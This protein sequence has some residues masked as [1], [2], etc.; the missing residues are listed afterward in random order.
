M[1]APARI[2]FAGTPEFAVPTLDA[3]LKS[4]HDV[5]AVLTQP[6]RPAGRGRKVQFGPVKQAALA[7]GLPVFQPVTLAGVDEQEQ[8]A[9]LS[10]DLMVVVAYGLLLPGTVLQIPRVACV[11]VHASLLPRWRGASPIQAALLAGD[12]ETGVSIMQMDA[13]LDTGPVYCSESLS[14]EPHESAAELHDRL[15]ALGGRLLADVVDTILSGELQATAQ[16]TAG[17]SYAGRIRKADS[18]INWSLPATSI[19]QLIRAYNPWPVAQTS[20]DGKQ[21]RCWAAQVDDRLADTSKQPGTIIGTDE[22]GIQVQTG[23]GV[24]VLT[25]V[26]APGRKRISATEFANAR[27]LAGAVLAS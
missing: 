26:Q 15:A 9:A 17:V 24:L 23:K 1:Q 14:I 20:L 16:P 11:N 3:L 8:L 6:D 21:L 4:G 25:Q 18:V 12:S 13:G 5:V 27:S 22:S 2:I 10:P 7:A 19:D